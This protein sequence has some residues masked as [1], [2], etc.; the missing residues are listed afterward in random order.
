VRGET[1]E[2]TDRLQ[3]AIAA[4]ARTAAGAGTNAGATLLLPRGPGAPLSVMIAPLGPEREVVGTASQPAAMLLVS[5][6]QAGRVPGSKL[7]GLY[8]LSPA[9]ARLLE[10]LVGG[11][12]LG[13]YAAR[14]G[15]SLSTVKTQLAH[16]FLK[17]GENRQSDLI[18]RVFRDLA[19]A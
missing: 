1:A 4:A 3:R 17:T 13:D 14:T 9:E 18:R 5:D 8:G 16:V 2:A 10:A 15:V 6:P 19:L 11:T 7:A 12:R